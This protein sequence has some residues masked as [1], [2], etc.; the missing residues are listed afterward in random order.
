MHSWAELEHGCAQ[1]MRDRAKLEHG[2]A[3]HVGIVLVVL[4]PTSIA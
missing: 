3:R 2:R 4:R 1:A